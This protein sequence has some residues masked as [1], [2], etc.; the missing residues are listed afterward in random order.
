MAELDDLFGGLDNTLDFLNEKKTVSSDGI[1]RIDLSKA[2][3][4]K[5]GYK[6]VIRLLPNLTKE[7]KVG[8]SA[9]EK[10]THYVNIKNPK[11]LAGWFD[12]PKNFGEKCPLT[13]LYYNMVNSKNAILVEKA[14]QL[15]YSKKY[16]SYALVIEDEQQPELVGKIMI[17]QYGKIIRDKILAEKN[18]EISGVSCNVF[19]LANGKD[20]V[21]LVKEIQTG[22]ETYPD[23]KNSMFRPETSAISLYNEE[24]REFKQ[25]PVQDGKVDPRAQKAVRD[26]LLKRD[27]DL[28]EFAAK[29]LTEEQQVKISEISNFLTGK[30]STSFAGASAPSSND[31]D[32]DEVV[33]KVESG[34]SMVSSS[35]DDDDFFKDF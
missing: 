3:D 2:K 4:K 7:G 11:E 24:R 35:A 16:Y 33:T 34:S 21:L 18:G 14:K 27:H 20:F 29:P 30:A 19:D 10:I 28:E 25:V 17:F 13:D 22:D 9:L 32:F 5:R 6:S 8:M 12:S 15:N 23:Y 31:F 1:Y 26:F